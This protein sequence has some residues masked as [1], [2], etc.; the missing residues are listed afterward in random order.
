M[1]ASLYCS[2]NSKR[3][4][5]EAISLTRLGSLKITEA[6]VLSIHLKIIGV[7]IHAL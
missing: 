4:S 1:L 6:H 2:H 5:I 3:V 7:W